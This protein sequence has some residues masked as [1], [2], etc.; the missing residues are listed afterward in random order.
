[1]LPPHKL[2][3]E[4]GHPEGDGAVAVG[5]DNGGLRQVFERQ[6]DRPVEVQPRNRGG[7]RD[8]EGDVDGP[9]DAV[10]GDL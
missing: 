3:E 10:V 8:P 2:L 7:I 6:P 4:N 9:A 1:M 5:G